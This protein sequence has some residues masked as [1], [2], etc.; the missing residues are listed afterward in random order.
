MGQMNRPGRTTP[1][2]SPAAVRILGV[3]VHNVT[4]EGA[5]SEI[6]AMAANG[7]PHHVVTVNPEFIMLA[8]RDRAF[9]D[10]LNRASLSL[11]DGHGVVWASR[12]GGTPLPERVTG[13]DTVER[14]AATASRLGLRLF[15]LGAAPGV[16]EVT[17]H[18][19][20]HRNPGL[21]VCGTHAGS[22]HP[23]DEEDICRRIRNA[24]PHVLLVAYGAP[25]QDLW[26][27]RNLRRLNVPVSMGVGGTFDFIAGKAARAPLWMRRS[28]LE[29]LHRLCMQPRRWRRMTALPRFAWA[30][31]G[32]ATGAGVSDRKDGA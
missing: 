14:L 8:R 16:A 17:A 12:L 22:P 15:L 10:I 5:V 24:S 23:E 30:V 11:P 6:A 20:R 1:A 19:L 27:A 4:M 32:D 28:G 9:R 2:Q 25:G 3:T 18:R 26:I 7:G 21:I 13:V 29:W 31:L